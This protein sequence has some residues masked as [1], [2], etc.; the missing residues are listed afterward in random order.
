MK[1]IPY[2][3][4]PIVTPM[5]TALIYIFE[6]LFRGKQRW[7]NDLK[8]ISSVRKKIKTAKRAKQDVTIERGQKLTLFHLCGLKGP[9]EGGLSTIFRYHSLEK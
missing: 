2:K 5:K 6:Q 7:F 8:M 3:A 4:N 9:F 1:Y